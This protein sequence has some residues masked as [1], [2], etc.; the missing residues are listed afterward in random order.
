MESSLVGL[1]LDLVSVLLDLLG[2][3]LNVGWVLDDPCWWD[4]VGLG[5]SWDNSLDQGLGGQWQTSV[6]ID[7]WGVVKASIEWESSLESSQWESSMG[8]ASWESS[9]GESSMGI[10]SW[11]SSQGKSGGQTSWQSN[12][13][14]LSG[15][16]DGGKNNSEGLHGGGFGCFLVEVRST[17]KR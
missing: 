15:G 6:G 7:A 13:G 17:I 12:L 10:A 16:N 14:A 8:V 11:E 2:D 9:Q 1:V 3:G 4:S 5:G